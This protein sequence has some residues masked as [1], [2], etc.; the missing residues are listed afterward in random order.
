MKRIALELTAEQEQRL[1][2]WLEL[3]DQQLSSQAA[4]VVEEAMSRAN[5][6]RFGE[7]VSAVLLPELEALF[8]AVCLRQDRLEQRL[9]DAEERLLLLER[10]VSRTLPVVRTR[11]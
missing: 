5:V 10:I 11:S 2:E 9:K 4:R 3:T 8:E 7:A 1:R 6:Q